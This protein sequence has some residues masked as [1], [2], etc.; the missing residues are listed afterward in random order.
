MVLSTASAILQATP[1]PDHG[2]PQT[3]HPN[4]LD[5][6]G[7]HGSLV[8]G[9]KVGAG[10]ALGST[11]HLVSAVIQYLLSIRRLSKIPQ[12]AGVAVA[13]VAAAAA[14]A[15]VVVVVAVAG[16]GV[17]AMGTVAMG[18]AATDTVEM[19][20]VAPARRLPLVGHLC[21][22]AQFQAAGRLALPI[23]MWGPPVL[24]VNQPYHSHNP[25]EHQLPIQMVPQ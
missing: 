9:V 16:K 23:S 7:P 17:V 4:V 20:A 25:Q 21:L 24:R 8:G 14:A 2:R 1:T 19:G 6:G 3:L 5:L 18:V 12:A 10:K 15:A 13:V 22:A 11:K